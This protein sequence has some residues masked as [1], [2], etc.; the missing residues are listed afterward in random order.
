MNRLTKEEAEILATRV[1]ND[2]FAGASDFRTALIRRAAELLEI[3][4]IPDRKMQT[5]NTL[6]GELTDRI[7]LRLRDMNLI[8]NYN[9]A[10]T[11]VLEELNKEPFL[12]A[13]RPPLKGKNHGK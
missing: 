8:T 6:A 5:P 4:P 1:V 10:W 9:A 13:E 12:S 11:I 7:L 2:F 3:Y